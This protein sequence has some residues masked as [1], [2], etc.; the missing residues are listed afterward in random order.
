MNFRSF[1]IMLAVPVKAGFNEQL[2][3]ILKDNLASVRARLPGIVNVVTY[4]NEPIHTNLDKTSQDYVYKRS[5]NLANA[6]NKLLYNYMDSWYD[7]VVWLDADIVQFPSNLPKL[8]CEEGRI[9]APRI[10]I[11]DTALYYDTF[12]HLPLNADKVSPNPPYFNSNADYIPMRCVGGCYSVPAWLY[13]DAGLQYTPSNEPGMEHL[14]F[15]RHARHNGIEIVVNQAIT[16]KHANLPKYG[17][18]FR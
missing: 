3:K 17:I 1:S 5:E 7:F 9:V 4:H 13:R 16:V 6:R 18:A 10:I 11:E 8:L 14:E 15:M 2:A 12:T